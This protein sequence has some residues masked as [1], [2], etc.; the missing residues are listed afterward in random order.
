MYL[1]S[2]N[3]P[4]VYDDYNTIVDNTSIHDVTNVRG[5][6]LHDVTRPIINYSYA[7]DYALWGTRPFGYHLTNVLLH[8]LNVILLFVLARRLVEDER[9]SDALLKIDANVVAFAAAMLFAVHPMIT[10]AV[11]YISGRSEVMCATWLLLAM[12]CGRRW[13]RGGGTR[14][15]ILTAGLW[16]A[17]VA[18]KEIGAMFPPILFCYDRFIV[19]GT[20]AEGR[21]RI[22]TVH[23]PLFSA[24]L[25]AGIVRLAL[26]ARVEHQDQVAT[27][28]PYALVE[29][30]VVRRYVGLILHPVGQAI[31]HEVAGVPTLFTATALTA[32]GLLVLMLVIAWRL[33]RAEGAVSLGILWFLLLLVPSSAL[34]VLGRGEPMAEHRVYAA[35]AGLFLAIGMGIGWFMAALTQL[36]LRVRLRYARLLANVAMALILLSLCTRTHARNVVWHDPVTL[37]RESVDLAPNHFRPRMLLGQAWQEAGRREEAVKQFKMAAK[38]RPQEE[39]IYKN[40]GLCLAEMGRLDEAAATFMQLRQLNPRSAFAPTGLGAIA[41]MS[42]QPGRARQYYIEALDL[43]PRSVPA[44]QSLAM[45]A[46]M[47]PANPA[48]ALRLCEEIERLAP[49]TPGNDECI[50][51]NRSRLADGSSRR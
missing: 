24:G 23:L 44:R 40:L 13:V 22:F 19:R 17:T 25:A 48:E 46:E 16:I 29:L 18:T 38:L 41:A 43:D 6:V 36:K 37:W 30:D 2:L 27:H 47:E 4:F 5:I 49:G 10:E 45:L 11:G 15:A 33:R 39:A 34:V 51:R 50:R 26:F 31:F 35:S 1:N 12:A 32:I 21:R 42:R 3:N 28:W 20:A 9:R 7:I 8:V 14:W